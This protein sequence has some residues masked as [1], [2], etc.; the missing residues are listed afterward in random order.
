MPALGKT[1]ITSPENVLA[2]LSRAMTEDVSSDGGV[3]SVDR[4]I[5]NMI[6]A[7]TEREQ[8]DVVFIDSRAGLSELAAP[9]VLG[10][11]AT[12]LLFGTAQ[13][14]TVEGYRA[15][16]AA[17][18]LLA[19]RDRALGKEAEWRSALRPVYAKSSMDE[20]IG[21]RFAEDIYELYSAHIYDAEDGLETNGDAFRFL[22]DD[23]DGPHQPLVI[24]FNANFIDFDP[25]RH[26]S[27]LTSSFYEQTFR[28]FL[29]GID[30]AMSTDS[31][32]KSV[33]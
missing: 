31:T 24:P 1:S 20:D 8:Y 28:P 22:R 13:R 26:P 27:H 25:A 12:V 10:L 33:A 18:Q 5:A 4:Q 6:H 21:Q 7:V 23:P 30:K 19:Q 14:Q 11:G 17:L 2:K 3:V 29:D 16:F 32:D 9:A 15:L